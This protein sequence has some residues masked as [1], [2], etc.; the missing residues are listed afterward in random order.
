[1][2]KKL[3]EKAV[4]ATHP[5]MLAPAALSPAAL[6]D[7]A[8]EVATHNPARK[9]D[10]AI[11]T[12][13]A[14]QSWR[15]IIDAIPDPAIALNAHGYIIHHNAAVIELFP[16][17]R[18]GSTISSVLRHPALLDA[19]A[20]MSQEPVK[21]T[22][23]I[24]ERVPVARRISATL[25]PLT[26]KKPN[27]GFPDLLIV[28]R[29]LTEEDRLDTM[30]ADFVANASHELRTP[31]AS[32]KGYIE[33]I[34]GAAKNDPP[35]QSRFLGIMHTQALRMT[36]LID[37][38]L[39]LT[40]VEMRA[41]LPPNG[42]VDLNEVAHYVAQTLDPLIAG[43]NAKLVVHELNR[44]ARIRGDRDEIV[45]AVLNLVQNAHK[46]GGPGVEI[47]VTITEAVSLDT[48]P[49]LLTL[50]VRDNGPGI[51]AE[52]LPRLAERF[53]RAPSA[54]REVE[55]TG[56]GLAIVKHVMTRHRGELEISSR[57]SFGSSFELIFDELTYLASPEPRARKKR[58]KNNK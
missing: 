9:I 46:Y 38:L 49:G 24:L 58:S 36:R 5:A 21:Q 8:V 10:C 44:P 19:I 41:H 45:Q 26:H 43:S 13:P 2:S 17:V 39:S 48:G 54:A 35:A 37:D 14:D 27:D 23:Q 28:F 15:I 47:E 34:Q 55:G 11:D 52:H 29:D 18:L 16:S 33:T 3:P 12:I 51:S 50:S 42:V 32:L 20:R 31:L 4:T 30:R 40:R 56:L 22:I 57:P 1:M 53:Y 6:G 7:V 25:T